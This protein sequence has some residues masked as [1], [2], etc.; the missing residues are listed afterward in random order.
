[1]RE[2][3]VTVLIDTQSVEGSLSD[4]ALFANTLATVTSNPEQNSETV[5]VSTLYAVDLLIQKC[6]N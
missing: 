3:L 6:G 4:L 5:T 1:M 2:L